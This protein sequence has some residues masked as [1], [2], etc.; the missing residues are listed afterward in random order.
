[1]TQEIPPNIHAAARRAAERIGKEL[2]GSPFTN[3]VG[4]GWLTRVIEQEFAQVLVNRV[5][6]CPSPSSANVVMGFANRAGTTGKPH[7]AD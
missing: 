7:A 2:S 6:F 4:E 1:M 3:Y 5:V